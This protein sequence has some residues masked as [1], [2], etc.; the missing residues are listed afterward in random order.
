MKNYIPFQTILK[1]QW[2]DSVSWRGWQKFEEIRDLTLSKDYKLH[3][4]IGYYLASNKDT[5]FI[6]TTVNGNSGSIDPL[7]IPL[8]SIKKIKI[9]KEENDAR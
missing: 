6:S 7:Q 5:I 1:I 4:S 3:F 8:K 2:M 9:L